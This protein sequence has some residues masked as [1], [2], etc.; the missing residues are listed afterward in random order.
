[1]CISCS[2]ADL[3]NM[4]AIQGPG[5]ELDRFADVKNRIYSVAGVAKF[6]FHWGFIPTVIY[7]G[8]LC[9]SVV[10]ELRQLR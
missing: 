1:M 9:Q 10:V 2:K 4:Q 6:L 3:F 7:L 5:S 8:E